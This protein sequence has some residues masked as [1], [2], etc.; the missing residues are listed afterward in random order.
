MY[1]DGWI[2]CA[3][4]DRISLENGSRHIWV[5]FGPGGDWDPDQ[6][7]W[8]L[9]N[10]DEDFSEANDLAAKNPEKLAE[11]K[12][13][14]LGRGREVPGQSADG[15]FRVLLYGF[16]LPT[17]V[18]DRRSRTTPALIHCSGGM[19]P[20]KL[21]IGRSLSLADLQIP[22][23]PVPKG[24]CGQAATSSAGFPC[25]SRAASSTTPTAFSV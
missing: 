20:H 24:D 19:S 23:P 21:I 22:P 8:E 14:V 6:D 17:A 5:R 12:E 25:T 4:L 16:R 18:A 11:L 2:A 13:T 3:R 1:K 9:Y 10:I 7:K 15:R